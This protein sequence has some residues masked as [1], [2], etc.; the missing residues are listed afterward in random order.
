MTKRAPLPVRELPPNK[1]LEVANP[2][3]ELTPAMMK[4][5]DHLMKFFDETGIDYDKFKPETLSY[6]DKK[7]AYPNFDQQQ[8]MAGQRD[9][10]KWLH[11]VRDIYQKEQGGNGRIH[12]IRQVC[13]GW[14]VMETH[15]FL[16]WLKFYEGNNHLKYKKAQL[17]Y[18]NGA[19]GYFLPIK[20]D[21]APEQKHQV[22]GPAIDFAKQ[23]AIQNEEKRQLIEKQRAKIIGRLDSVEK[24]LRSN[25]GQTFAG[26]EFQALMEAI[27]QLKQ[28]IHIVN[29]LSS[30]T[31]LY[32]DMIVREANVLA[33]RGFT[34]AADLLYK[35]GQANNPPPIDLGTN[36]DTPPTPTAPDSPSA[37][38]NPGAPGG[39]PSMGP[40]MSQNAPASTGVP[41]VGPNDNSPQN[42]KGVSK[43]GPETAANGP[44]SPMPQGGE[45]KGPV[46]E[47][48]Q[49][50]D[51]GVNTVDDKSQS[52][53]DKLEVS[54]LIEVDST[55]DD[56]MVT[57]AQAMPP[58]DEPMTTSPA[59]APLNPGPPAPRL[60]D[61][62]PA[63]DAPATEE[64]LEVTEDEAAPPG[65]EEAPEEGIASDFDAKIDAVFADTTI[66][67]I[68][69]KL[70]DISK[71]YRTREM[72]RQ[73]AFVDMMLDSKG[74][75]SFFPS[76]SEATNKALEANNYISTRVDDIL[77][78]LRGAMSSKET[79]LKGKLQEDAD[80]EKARKQQRKE[81]ESMEMS[82][83]GK[84]KPEVEIEE[85]LGPKTPKAPAAP[86]IPAG[87]APAAAPRPLG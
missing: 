44:A 50:L 53:D 35:T 2:D 25:D 9:T 51:K 75:A 43:Q 47:F 17:W 77:S 49:N 87:P 63:P 31:R 10:E 72:P 14:D 5:I 21:P 30:S 6:T 64:P 40:G 86:P 80:K 78:K 66:N 23:D 48:L 26:P 85:D 56:L 13:S 28:K 57:E 11:A 18:E 65:G 73:L 46:G 69:A 62:P 36:K 16:N 34:K 76:L 4:K 82:G 68:V 15:D 84:E 70:E 22:D 74:L 8:Y 45:T 19:P 1:Q 59:P 7:K 61:E 37:P 79:D 20:P 38:M 60:P 52:E 29:K 54:D 71:T 42:L 3:L 24:L 33:R 58:I 55:E 32:E 83:K 27:Y 39:L 81:Q 41:E 67:D 12:S